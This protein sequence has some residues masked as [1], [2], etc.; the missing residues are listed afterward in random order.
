MTYKE[1]ESIYHCGK[2]REDLCR[3]ALCPFYPTRSKPKPT[4]SGPVK[5]TY[6][7]NE[8]HWEWDE[9]SGFWTYK[10]D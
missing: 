6:T 10:E 7:I 8:G 3:K 2:G 1:C 4:R 9:I 5:A